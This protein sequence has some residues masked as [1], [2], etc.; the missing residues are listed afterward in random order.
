MLLVNE[1]FS[2]WIA[3]VTASPQNDAS[4]PMALS[5]LLAMPMMVWF[6]CSTTPFYY[7]E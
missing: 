3:V 2:T 6:L 5:M 7:G 4:T 1:W